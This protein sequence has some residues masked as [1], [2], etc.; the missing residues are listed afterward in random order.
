M[1]FRTHS[2]CPPSPAAAFFPAELLFKYEMLLTASL[3]LCY[4][5]VVP[6]VLQVSQRYPQIIG[7]GKQ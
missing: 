4:G 1:T 7:V 6:P 3:V 5:P 2:D